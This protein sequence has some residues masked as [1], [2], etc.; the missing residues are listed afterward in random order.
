M[1]CNGTHFLLRCSIV[2]CTGWSIVYWVEQCVLGGALCTVL[3]ESYL[4]QIVDHPLHY[5]HIHVV[6]SSPAA[7]N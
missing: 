5:L 1:Y 6:G 2:Y 3:C 7:T 4:L